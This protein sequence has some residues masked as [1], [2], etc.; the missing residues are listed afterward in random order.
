MTVET[1]CL[2]AV[3]EADKVEVSCSK[4]A[5]DGLLVLRLK[6]GSIKAYQEC[7]NCGAVWWASPDNL[8]NKPVYKLISA[9]VEFRNTQGGNRPDVT[10]IFPKN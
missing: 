3:D 6:P 5:C 7:P 9:L 8:Y 2:A 1:R 4:P 10:I